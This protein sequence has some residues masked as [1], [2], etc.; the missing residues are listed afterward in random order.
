MDGFKCKNSK[1]LKYKP[2]H[3]TRPVS[4]LGSDVYEWLVVAVPVG[5]ASLTQQLLKQTERMY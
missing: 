4:G 3:N 1:L 5:T 2:D